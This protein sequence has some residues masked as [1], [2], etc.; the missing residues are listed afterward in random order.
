MTD[1]ERTVWRCIWRQVAANNA[2]VS[3]LYLRKDLRGCGLGDHLADAA[4]DELHRNGHV[5]HGIEEWTFELADSGWQ[6]MARA[7]AG[8]GGKVPSNVV[9]LT[10]RGGKHL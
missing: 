5:V 2:A 10:R 4:I 3:E 1:D 9:P 8:T 7:L 6:L